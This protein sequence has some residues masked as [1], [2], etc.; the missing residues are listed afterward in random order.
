MKKILLIP[1]AVFITAMVA[2]K[3]SKKNRKTVAIGNKGGVEYS[4]V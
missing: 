4:P 1:V 3:E 2:H